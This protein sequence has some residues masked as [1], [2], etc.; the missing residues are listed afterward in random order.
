MKELKLH[1]GALAPSIRKQLSDQ[2]FKFRGARI[3]AL[4]EKQT[5]IIRL[6]LGGII[7]DAEKE[8]ANKR[9]FKQIKEHVLEMNYEHNKG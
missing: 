3:S 9:L 1:F 8:R 2:G 7:S 6:Y 5:A 4:Q